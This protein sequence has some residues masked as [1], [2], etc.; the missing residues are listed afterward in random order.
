MDNGK[1]TEIIACDAGGT[2][3][4]MVIVDKEGNFSIG[5]SATTPLDQSIGYWSSLCDAYEYWST[6]LERN[7]KTGHT[8]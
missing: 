6:D 2:M 1:E 3:I 5:K 7:S 8:K 4:D